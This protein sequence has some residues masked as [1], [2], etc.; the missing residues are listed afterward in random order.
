MQSWSTADL[1][2]D[3]S[4]LS[5]CVSGQWDRRYGQW[6]GFM[7]SERRS[8]HMIGVEKMGRRLLQLLSAAYPQLIGGRLPML[9]ERQLLCDASACIRLCLL[10]ARDSAESSGGRLF[11]RVHRDLHEQ[12]SAVDVHRTDGGQIHDCAFDPENR[13][14]LADRSGASSR[15][16]LTRTC[17]WRNRDDAA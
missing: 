5:R 16:M 6:R 3:Q 17:R 11:V 13:A 8:R 10:S 15:K 14:G 9:R 1:D 2:G 4:R 7:C 12:R